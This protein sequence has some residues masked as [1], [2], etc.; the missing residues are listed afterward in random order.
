MLAI[1]IK[2]NGFSRNESRSSISLENDD[3]GIELVVLVGDGN[4][5]CTE[6]G[7]KSPALGDKAGPKPEDGAFAVGADASPETGDSFIAV[8]AEAG[9]KP[10]DGVV[11]TGADSS[12]ETGD[13]SDTEGAEAGATAGEISADV[14]ADAIG[15]DTGADPGDRSSVVEFNACVT[16]GSPFLIEDGASLSTP[17]LCKSLSLFFTPVISFLNKSVEANSAVF[18]SFNAVDFSSLLYW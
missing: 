3:I 15:A 8:G 1:T 2:W 10:E 4:D 11:A 13:A 5:V 9:A 16:S 17:S 7:E 12:P 14:G 18:D 6:I